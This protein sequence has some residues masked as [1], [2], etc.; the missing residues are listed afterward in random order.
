MLRNGD[1]NRNSS[2]THFYYLIAI[3]L[4]QRSHQLANT[5]MNVAT[6]PI[7]GQG[8]FAMKLI[9]YT[10]TDIFQ[11]LLCTHYTCDFF[12]CIIWRTGNSM[13]APYF[14]VVE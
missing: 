3:K 12:L 1:G 14:S 4:R 2:S 9:T 11:M 5:K 7:K 13:M 6:S 10:L 8:T